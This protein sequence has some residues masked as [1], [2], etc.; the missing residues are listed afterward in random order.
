MTVDE[1][2]Q[3]RVCVRIFST[4]MFRTT[5]TGVT[6]E[7]MRV[8]WIWPSVTKTLIKILTSSRLMRVYESR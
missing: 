7:L 1:R 2:W 6:W 8:D 4:L 3:A 5:R